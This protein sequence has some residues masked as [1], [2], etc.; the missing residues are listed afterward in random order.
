MNT[1]V[2]YKRLYETAIPSY[3]CQCSEDIMRTFVYYYKNVTHVEYDDIPQAIYALSSKCCN[4]NKVLTMQEALEF[5]LPGKKKLIDS[6]VKNITDDLIAGNLQNIFYIDSYFL[7]NH[8]E[9]FIK[10][11]CSV[12]TINICSKIA[13]EQIHLLPKIFKNYAFVSPQINLCICSESF[14][15]CLDKEQF[16]IWLS[17]ITP[18]L[19]SFYCNSELS[20]EKLEILYGQLM[21]NVFFQGLYLTMN[22]QALDG[23]IRN[24]PK[25]RL[26]SLGVSCGEMCVTD[27][28]RLV[29]CVVKHP[30]LRHLDLGSQV[31]FVGGFF[32]DFK[33]ADKTLEEAINKRSSD[34]LAIRFYGKWNASTGFV[35]EAAFHSDSFVKIEVHDEAST[36]KTPL[37][38]KMS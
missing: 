29:A 1:E 17:V 25:L 32:S 10:K 22:S 20:C 23:L 11:G 9:A 19:F 24:F 37:L 26:T 5:L 21:Q 35:E 2:F 6:I 27:M 8:F 33:L 3:Y 28:T 34:L 18:N 14:S 15:N 38:K 31:N 13:E 12:R 30:T 36:E 16:E 7:C 4:L